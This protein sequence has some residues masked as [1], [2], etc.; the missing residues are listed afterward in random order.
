METQCI[1]FF[2]I[3]EIVTRVESAM[4]DFRG[5][6]KSPFK[7]QAD[8]SYIGDCLKYIGRKNDRIYFRYYSYKCPLKKGRKFSINY[9]VFKDGWAYANISSMIQKPT[10]NLNKLEIISSHSIHL[11]KMKENFR[12]N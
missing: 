7:P 2:K 6:R 10:K 1:D 9:G 3:G 8:Y 5:R 12:L 11:S 4:N